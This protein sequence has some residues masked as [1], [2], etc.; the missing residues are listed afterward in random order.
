MKKLAF[1][2]FIVLISTSYSLFAIP[3][4]KGNKTI[5]NGIMIVNNPKKPIYEINRVELKEDLTIGGESNESGSIGKIADIDVD[6]QGRI[7][8]L[9]FQEM[10]IRIY[11]N[12]G[13]IKTKFGR[14]GQGPGEMQLPLGIYYDNKEKSLYVFD[15]L[16]GNII[17]FDLD[18]RLKGQKRIKF[19]GSLMGISMD[20][21]N[22][23]YY[24][25]ARYE[26]RTMKIKSCDK[27]MNVEKEYGEFPMMKIDKPFGPRLHWRV[28]KM[29]RLIV[30][31][32][33]KYELLIYKNGRL[34]RRIRRD[35]DFVRISENEKAEENK[36]NR[37]GKELVFPIF[38]SAFNRINCDEQGRIFIKTWQKNSEN[39]AYL[40]DIY[41]SEGIYTT[42]VYIKGAPLRILK[43]K[44]YCIDED[45]MGFQIL[46]RYELKWKN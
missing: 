39:D 6:E 31:F 46:K 33:D 17:N 12:N 4:W 32:P 8:L 16:T 38:H 18:G 1:F 29:D 10:N 24:C 42:A 13:N 41:D 30:G 21:M 26:T 9:D 19:D 35:Y 36:D 14:K 44:L 25:S 28:D 5:E 23:I 37:T 2:V 11:D 34:E 40:Y 22:K 3:Q 45:I 43:N 20:S 27:M 7:Y 15:H